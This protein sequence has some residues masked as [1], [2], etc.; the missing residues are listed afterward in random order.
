MLKA[1]LKKEKRDK[2]DKK[3]KKKKEGKDKKTKVLRTSPMPPLDSFD[4]AYTPLSYTPGILFFRDVACHL[5]MRSL[6]MRMQ[7]SLVLCSDVTSSEEAFLRYSS[8]LV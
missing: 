7:L 1:L 2:K 4:L 6:S 8:S 5:L 3:S